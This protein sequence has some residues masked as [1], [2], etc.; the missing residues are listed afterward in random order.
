[1]NSPRIF[2][3]SSNPDLAKAISQKSKIPLGNI[4]LGIFSDGEI[5]VWIG[6]DVNNSN[7]FILQSNSY[8][9]NDNIIELALIA[10]ALRRSG[11]YKITAV[12]PYF[13]YSRKEK[14]SRRGEPIS[15]KVIADLIVTSGINKVV[16]LDLHAD[17]IVGFFNVPVIYLSA[18]ETLAERIKKEKFTSPVVVAPDVGG[19][20]RARNFA[21]LIDAPLAVIEKKRKADVRD[22]MEV[23]S[24]SGEVTGDTAIVIDDVIST[25]GTIAESA[26]VLKEKGVK[27]VI[28]CA[29]HGVFANEA[30]KRL[31]ESAA[32]KIFVTDSVAQKTKSPK[33]EV[34][35]VATLFADCL[36]QE[37]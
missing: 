31:E 4:D 6:D 26:K 15:A 22:Q 29:T 36:S 30:V 14:Q 18:L 7:V 27:K 3:G 10:D 32:D 11:A 13:G 37:T 20:R 16:C 19:V 1:M 33:L 28:V 35:S 17:A 9:V 34:V 2:S 23:L 21:A 5:D 24:M 8:P 12:I 25:G